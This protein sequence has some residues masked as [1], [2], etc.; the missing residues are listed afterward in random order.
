[1]IR[2]RP[3]P[4]IRVVTLGLHWRSGRLL[5]AEILDD[6][7]QLKGVRPLGGGVNFG[8]TWRVALAREFKEEIGV[9]IALKG[10]PLVTESIFNYEGTVGHEVVFLSDIEFLDDELERNDSVGFSD[11][12]G[13]KG[14][15]RWFDLATLDI[16]G[17]PK[18]YPSGLK[19]LLLSRALEPEA[20]GLFAKLKN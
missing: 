3:P 12:S 19:Q 16:D 14:L 9:E 6:G 4:I 18:L 20:G 2:W 11:D 5:A 13:I 10:E 8:E 1:M 7:D 15:A 17:G